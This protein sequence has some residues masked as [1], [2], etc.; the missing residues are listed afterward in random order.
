M[1]GN[2][3]AL[4]EIEVVVWIRDAHLL[5]CLLFGRFMDLESL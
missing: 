5:F 4:V 2:N 1:G 3:I